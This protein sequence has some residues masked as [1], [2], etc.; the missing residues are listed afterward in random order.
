MIDVKTLVDNLPI[1][2]VLIDKNRRILLSNRHAEKINHLDRCESQVKRFGDMVGCPNADENDAGCGFAEFCYLCQAKAMIELAFSTKK[3]IAQF[4]TNISMSSM[5]VRS[6]RMT[7]TYILLNER[8]NSEQE[9]CVVTVE[10]MTELKEK[11]RLAAVS[12]TIGAICHELNQ[13]LQAIM[14]NVE[15]LAE[16]KLEDK[17]ISR[18]E[19]IYVEIERIKSINRKLRNITRYQT[20]PYLST[21]ILDVE[22]SAG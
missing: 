7:I 16:F 22:R 17:A 8:L 4:E 19:K 20:K 15:L 3:N 5:G 18:I 10:D 11:E 1:A 12:E 13:P 21:S 6:L 9:M 14:G 2:I